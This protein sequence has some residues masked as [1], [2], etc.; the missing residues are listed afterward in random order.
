[1]DAGDIVQISYP[2]LGSTGTSLDLAGEIDWFKIQADEGYYELNWQD[3]MDPESTTQTGDVQVTAYKSDGSKIIGP[4]DNGMS[5]GISF[6]KDSDY[7]YIKVEGKSSD[8]TG[9]YILYLS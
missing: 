7:I 4:I 9:T 1:M 2:E 5:E 6:T 8:S 3:S